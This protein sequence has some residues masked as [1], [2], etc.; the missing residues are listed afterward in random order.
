MPDQEDG[1]MPEPI[2][3]AIV[4]KI[5]GAAAEAGASKVTPGLLKR[6]LGPS[7]NV[8]GEALEQ[9]TRYRL[10]NVLNIME[11]ADTKS[12]ASAARG[13]VNP[14]VA[15]VLL[16]EGSYCDDE[17]MAEY[18]AGVLAG[19][20][21]PTGRDDRAVTWCRVLTGLSSFQ[22]RAHYLLYREWAACLSGT[23]LN[24]AGDVDLFR[25]TMEADLLEF[26]ALLDP[27]ASVGSG[28]ALVHSIPGLANAGLLGSGFGFGPRDRF[29][30]DSPFENV[31]QVSPSIVGCELYGWA[32][33]LPGLPPNE[34]TSKAA[35]F[36]LEDPIARLSGITLPNYSGPA[37]IRPDDPAV[38]GLQ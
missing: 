24:L 35:V 20:R 13:I 17:L 16:E 32:Q 23:G 37:V 2:T 29:S 8:I 10:R 18:L 31:L 12:A 9:Y 4:A 21:T 22:V 33:G 34:F 36:E 6:V 1:E 28:E 25:A 3:G 26:E 11:R 15:H 7:A 5:A 14:R 30:P 38:P 27:E 19:S